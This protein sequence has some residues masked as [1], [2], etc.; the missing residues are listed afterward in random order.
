MPLPDHSLTIYGGCNCDAIRFKIA[1]PAL[2]SRPIHFA[3]PD[4]G[5]RLPMIA[6]DHCNDCR[7]QTG[8]ILPAWICTPIAYVSVVCAPRSEAH[9]QTPKGRIGSTKVREEGGNWAPAERLFSGG[10]ES[11]GT[12]LQ[13]YESSEGR[14]RSYC[15]R[16]GT[17]LAYAI[18]PTPDGW[19]EMLDVLLG[20]IDRE[21]LEGHQLSPE[22]QLWWDCGI[23]WV[24]RLS[25]EGM[26]KEVP[27]HPTYKPD[28]FV[29]EATPV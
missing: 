16:C 1:I 4:S 22:R 2:D 19:I 27:R 5:V 9:G 18:F 23:E 21:D 13:F 28:E 7:A 6:L 26:G 11:E 3:S 14:R 12:Y 20:T 24:R 15:G 17:N 8:S 29:V 25:K 10:V